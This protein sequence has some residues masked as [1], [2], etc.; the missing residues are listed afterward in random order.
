MVVETYSI[1]V[2]A[3][4]KK[5]LSSLVNR[6]AEIQSSA[7]RDDVL[8]AY[9]DLVKDTL[10][11]TGL[12]EADGGNGNKYVL[13]IPNDYYNR[14][15]F[16]IGAI[17]ILGIGYKSIEKIHGISFVFPYEGRVPRRDDWFPWKWSKFKRDNVRDMTAY[18]TTNPDDLVKYGETRFEWLKGVLTIAGSQA[19]N[20]VEY[21]KH[22][23][24]IYH[25]AMDTSF[26]V[27]LFREAGIPVDTDWMK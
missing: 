21:G 15:S 5:H 6:M 11:T 18:L 26:R 13:T 23:P 14:M 2:N 10:N 22:C 9:F 27:L 25:S 19:N 4:I 8:W 20:Q 3:M 7:S 24:L 1:G 17:R 16:T 12:K